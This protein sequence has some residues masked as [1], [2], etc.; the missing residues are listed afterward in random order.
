MLDE[1]QHFSPRLPSS[2][3]GNHKEDQIYCEM[4]SSSFTATIAGGPSVR[5][6]ISLQTA[7][8]SSL[9]DMATEI[10]LHLIWVNEIVLY[11]VTRR[12][13]TIRCF[14]FQQTLWIWIC[15]CFMQCFCLLFLVV[16]HWMFNIYMYVYWC[17][18]IYTLYCFLFFNDKFISY[19]IFC[20][21]CSIH[22]I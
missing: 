19:W 5:M 20:C 2:R 10:P 15:I 21:S 14:K 3:K 8:H 11:C 16:A 7:L 4:P 1:C 22:Y 17:I 18:Y 13:N 9:T 12:W 6:C